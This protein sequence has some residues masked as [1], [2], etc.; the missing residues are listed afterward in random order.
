MDQHNKSEIE[1][2]MK[3]KMRRKKHWNAS[4]TQNQFIPDV[5]PVFNFKSHCHRD[6]INF[7]LLLFSSHSLLCTLVVALK[8]LPFRFHRW[9]SNTII[10]LEPIACSR[11]KQ[12]KNLILSINC[13]FF[14]FF[15]LYHWIK[16][17]MEHCWAWS[18]HLYMWSC[19]HITCWQLWDHKCKNTCGGR[20]TWRLCKL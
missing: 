10:C 14:F 9:Q 20:D 3:R 17:D 1:K 7:F 13:I 15:F 18:I 19:T 4:G 6:M 16:V 8:T 5:I 2:K 12:E 11:D